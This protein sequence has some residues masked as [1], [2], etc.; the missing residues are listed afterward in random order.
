MAAIGFTTLPILYYLFDF[1]NRWQ[2]PLTMKILGVNATDHPGYEI[3]YVFCSYATVHGGILIA[4]NVSF[5]TI[6][7]YIHYII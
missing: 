3:H 4:G 5:G 6:S 2:L 7:T 1:D